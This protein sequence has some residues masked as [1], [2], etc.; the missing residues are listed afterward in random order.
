MQGL[1]L[2]TPCHKFPV[3]KD[4]AHMTKV[5]MKAHLHQ[6]PGVGSLR[7]IRGGGSGVGPAL[8]RGCV[9]VNAVSVQTESRITEDDLVAYLASGCKPKAKWRWEDEIFW[10]GIGGGLRGWTV[11]FFLVVRDGLEMRRCEDRERV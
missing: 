10:K 4:N 5:T 8:N 9:R 3:T 1:L 7:H 6:V 2:P 11:P